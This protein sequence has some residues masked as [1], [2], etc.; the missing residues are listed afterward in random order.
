MWR[1]FHPLPSVHLENIMAHDKGDGMGKS[2]GVAMYMVVCPHFVVVVDRAAFERR[3]F[4]VQD[5][6]AVAGIF[7]L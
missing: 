5:M 1:F 7:G 3:I 2:R 6:P 4:K